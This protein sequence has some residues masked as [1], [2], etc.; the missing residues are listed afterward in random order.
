MEGEKRKQ[1]VAFHKSEY[2]EEPQAIAFAPGRFHLIGEHSAF[3][4]DKTLS[5][6][7]DIPVFVAISKRADFSMK[8]YFVESEDR[9]KAN[10]TS[11]KVKKE[12]RWANALKAIAFA[13]SISGYELGGMNV[14]VSSEVQPSAGFGITTAIKIASALCIRQLL[15]KRIPDSEILKIIEK[16][17]KIFL[18]IPNAI[19]DNLVALYAKKNTLFI[20]NH[21]H[22]TFDYV[23]YPFSDKLMILCDA[24][25]PRISVWNEET[26]HESQN[27]LLLGELHEVK[28]TVYGGWQYETNTQEIN[29]VL[30]TVSEDTRRKL[31][32][33]MREHEDVLLAREALLAKDFYAFARAVNHSHESMKELFNLSCP[34]IDWLVKRVLELEPN[35]E[36]IRNPETCARI[37]GKGFGRC[38][39]AFIR[40]ADKTS[41]DEKL[42][43]YERIFG[44]HPS[45]HEV[46]PAAGAKLLKI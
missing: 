11:L 41:F 26:L 1:I 2:G 13:F 34:E 17:N 38:L 31:L 16:A 45:S 25:V 23:D 39:Y 3:F 21:A 22:Q 6:A 15:G 30:S 20:T 44:F 8:F 10:Y 43:E 4:K 32:C 27:A 9:R 36:I 14:T 29:E 7:I 42:S 12:D 37:T 46:H 33:I 40:K 35:L 24:S 28:K 5:V 19:A 18:E